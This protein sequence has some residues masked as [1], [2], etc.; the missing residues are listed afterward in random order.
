MIDFNLALADFFDGKQGRYGD[1]V[2]TKDQL[3]YRTMIRS[4]GYRQDVLCIRTPT[5][6]IGNSSML[7][8]VGTTYDRGIRTTNEEHT[9]EQLA[10]FALNIPMFPFKT[11]KRLKLPLS[12][13]MLVGRTDIEYIFDNQGN[14]FVQKIV[15]KYT[16]LRL[17]DKLI[18]I[19]YN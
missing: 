15:K 9:P 3:I 8:L 12:D 11:L 13:L 1:Y 16:K 6:Y 14:R 19:R 4:E 2:V 18:W 10:L 5:C 7:D 17:V